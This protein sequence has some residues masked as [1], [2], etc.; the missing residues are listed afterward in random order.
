LIV[1][2]G[3]MLYRLMNAGPSVED[4]SASVPI[5]ASDAEVAKMVVEFPRI[6]D[7]LN[8]LPTRFVYLPTLTDSLKV[9]NPPSAAFNTMMKVNCETGD[10]T[11]QEFGN[12]IS[13]EA[14]FIPRRPNGR[15]DEG[16]LAIFSFDPANRTS[17]LVLLDA[18]HIDSEPVAVIR[19]PQRVPRDCTEIGSRRPDEEV[20]GR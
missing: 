9:A 15:E 19:R 5:G 11:R 4:T 12:R 3:Y 18:A 1:A 8:A 14:T 13:G 16:Y 2:D 6:N 10:I 17:D 7:A 20:E